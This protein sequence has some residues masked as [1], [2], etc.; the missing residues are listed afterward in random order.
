MSL[1]SDEVLSRGQEVTR[2]ILRQ[3]KYISNES[4][5]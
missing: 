4:P 1:L 2:D 3:M 5:E